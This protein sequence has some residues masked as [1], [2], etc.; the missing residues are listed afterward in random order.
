MLSCCMTAM[1]PQSRNAQCLIIVNTD[2]CK[3]PKFLDIRKL[4]CNRRKIQP[5]RPNQRVISQKDANGMENI[6]DPDPPRGTV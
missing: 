4:S 1:C 6:E 2:Y 3:A 5:K